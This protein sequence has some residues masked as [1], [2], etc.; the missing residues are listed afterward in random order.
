MY[1]DA[2]L[3]L[4]LLKAGGVLIFDEN[5]LNLQYPVDMRPKTAM[6][7]FG[8]QISLTEKETSIMENVLRIYVEQRRI[9]A[10]L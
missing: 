2:A 7:A 4:G 9:R 10:R 8:K 3:S 5:L 6:D 1:L